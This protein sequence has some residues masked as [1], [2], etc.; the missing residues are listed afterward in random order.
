MV[1]PP[2]LARVHVCSLKPLT[3]AQRAAFEK[4]KASVQ[5]AKEA[6]AAAAVNAAIQT[7]LEKLSRLEVAI[8]TAQQFQSKPAN[9]RTEAAAT[10]AGVLSNRGL[11]RLRIELA[12]LAAT[13]AVAAVAKE[14]SV[15][16]NAAIKQIRMLAYSSLH[17]GG[18]GGGGG[19][20]S[21]AAKK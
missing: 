9:E 18:G 2:E 21:A 8:I 17:G 5:S 20:G 12:E 4:L 10:A 6:A 7:Y 16:L 3:D 13:P 11:D 15:R 1:E 19:S 14:Q